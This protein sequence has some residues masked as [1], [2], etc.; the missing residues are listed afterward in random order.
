MHPKQKA[1]LF[2][3]PTRAC[4]LFF[5]L[6]LKVLPNPTAKIQAKPETRLWWKL[7][8]LASTASHACT[9]EHQLS[10]QA[11]SITNSITDLRRAEI[12]LPVTPFP[13]T[14]PSFSSPSTCC[15]SGASH[16]PNVGG[17]APLGKGDSPHTGASYLNQPTQAAF[18]ILGFNLFGFFI[19][20]TSVYSLEKHRK[21]KQ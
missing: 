17:P 14:I 2:L 3:V 13:G 1:L 16:Q 15:T 19:I 4:S 6:T 7:G 11:R 21:T 10:S 20:M 18:R 5:C 9:E 8:S 12:S